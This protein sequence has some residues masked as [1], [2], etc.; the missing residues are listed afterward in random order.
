[1][2]Y[3][4]DIAWQFKDSAVAV[5]LLASS[6]AI[7][8]QVGRFAPTGGFENFSLSDHLVA[9]MA[10]LPTAFAMATFLGFSILLL[11]A[12]GKTTANETGRPMVGALTMIVPFVAVSIAYRFFTGTAYESSDFVMGAAFVLLMVN[13]TWLKYPLT[14]PHGIIS[15]FL[16]A[17]PVTVMSSMRP[18]STVSSA[19][20]RQLSFR[21]EAC[22]RHSVGE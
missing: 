5:P 2:S 22:R 14:G 1:M 12:T 4:K 8:W 10:A 17:T 11:S 18:P 21:I 15:L 13:V 19:R 20:P 16:V 6:L 3:Q 9:A 7:T